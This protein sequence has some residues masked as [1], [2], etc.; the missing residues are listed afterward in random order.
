MLDATLMMS[1]VPRSS[2]QTGQQRNGCVS[3]YMKYERTR[4]LSHSG[5]VSKYDI[6]K[7]NSNNSVHLDESPPLSPLCFYFLP[8]PL[9]RLL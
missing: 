8:L 2:V 5:Y 1:L 7:G 4:L 3:L 6:K 9:L